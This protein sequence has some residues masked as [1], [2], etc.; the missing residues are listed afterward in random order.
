[1]GKRFEGNGKRDEIN[2]KIPQYL[3]VPANDRANASATLRA[4][5]VE[6]PLAANKVILL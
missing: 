1:M 2:G 6:R 3:N 5:R 4:N